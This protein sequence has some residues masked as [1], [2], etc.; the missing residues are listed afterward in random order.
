MATEPKPRFT[1]EEYLARERQAESRNE[2]LHGEI[3]A[4]TGASR[5]HNR[6]VLN[7]A[8]SLDSQL[9]GKGCEVFASEMRVRVPAM[10]LYTYPDLAVACGEPR[11]EDGE[12]DT[13]LN[14]VLIVEVLS[15]ST[16]SYDRGIKFSYYRALPSLAEY[17]LLS[18]DRAHAEHFVREA[19]DRWVLTETDDPAKTLELPS[20]GCTLALSDV[21]DRVFS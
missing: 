8:I 13:L 18:Q 21:Y 14:P 5:R 9:R 10:D 19:S 2:Y 1:P 11:F 6:I 16:E 17:L 12:V 15:K 4:M 7:T 20:V 3:F